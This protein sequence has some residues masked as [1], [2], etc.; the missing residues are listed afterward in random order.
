M[1]KVKIAVLFSFKRLTVASKIEF[2]RK[3]AKAMTGNA[4]FANPDVSML[5]LNAKTSDLETGYQASLTGDITAKEQ[6][7]LLVKA[8][9]DLMEKQANYVTRI[10]ENNPKL[11][12]EAGFEHTTTETKKTASPDKLKAFEADRADKNGGIMLSVAALGNADA[13]VFVLSADPAA[14]KTD[15]YGVVVAANNT[16]EV[17]IVVSHSRKT[18]ILGLESGKRYHCFAYGVNVAGKGAETSTI[19][20]VAP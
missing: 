4:N 15:A 7:K 9:D 8:W 16:E 6:L 3:I 20:I 13:L 11:I 2:G 1:K 5:I 18:T 12:V 10:A 19:S 17:R 14:T